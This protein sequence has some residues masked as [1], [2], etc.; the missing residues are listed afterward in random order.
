MKSM[1][2][3]LQTEAQSQPLTNYAKKRIVVDLDGEQHAIAAPTH[4]FVDSTYWLALWAGFCSASFNKLSVAS[5][6][7]YVFATNKFMGWL[8]SIPENTFDSN[9]LVDRYSRYLLEDL[10]NESNGYAMS[11]STVIRHGRDNHTIRLT[12][13]QRRAIDIISRRPK[14][15]STALPSPSMADWFLGIDWL[16][17]EMEKLELEHLYLKLESPRMVESSYRNFCATLLNEIQSFRTHCLSIQAPSSEEIL[18]DDIS[19]APVGKTST[20]RELHKRHLNRAQLDWFTPALASL[21]Q[22]SP[23][24]EFFFSSRYGKYAQIAVKKFLDR[25]P[26]CLPHRLYFESKERMAQSPYVFNRRDLVAPSQL[27]Q[28]LVTQLLALSAVQPRMVGR[29]SLRNA[30]LARNSRG[31]AIAIQFRYNKTRSGGQLKETV[32][33]SA[34]SPTGRALINYVRLVKDSQE[35]LDKDDLNHLTP[36]Y[37]KT[38]FDQKL[39]LPERGTTSVIP[40]LLTYWISQ[41]GTRKKIAEEYEKANISRVFFESFLTVM[42]KCDHSFATFKELGIEE[43]DGLRVLPKCIWSCAS[44]KQL[45]VF[46]RSDVYRVGDLRNNNSHTSETER[47]CY[48]TDHN[49]DWVNR[50]GRVTRM[51]I[52]DM[53]RHVFG[54]SVDRVHRTAYERSLRTEVVNALDA[55]FRDDQVAINAI[56]PDTLE[57]IGASRHRDFNQIVV[58]DH[59]S[60]VVYLLHYLSQATR[61]SECLALNAPSFLE[62]TVAPRC[63]WME[64]L[65]DERLSPTAVQEGSAAYEKIAKK[66]PPLFGQHLRRS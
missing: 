12:P 39:S 50:N 21:P 57:L 59:P 22:D 49:K 5:K 47:L 16:R 42:T 31:R 55:G 6:Q 63:E 4:A 37:S 52:N 60:T 18:A 23:A 64:R 41:P 11:V 34:V 35:L 28:F 17:G 19:H 65:L 32:S 13:G 26:S 2:D 29:L 40:N 44:L 20:E 46:A 9:D 38:R 58:L 61:H 56:R 33:Y 54:A 7:S 66:L 36:F 51:V 24:A 10:R 48:L 25:E 53:Q 1:K 8:E 27:E 15:I 30:V 3:L 62:H 43:Q 14:Q 45:G